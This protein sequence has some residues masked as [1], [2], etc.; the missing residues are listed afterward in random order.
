MTESTLEGCK[1]L[2]VED[3]FFQ[4]MDAKSWLEKAGAE[5]VG[6]TGFAEDVPALLH[7]TR[8]DAAVVDINL[9]AGA[10]Y[11]VAHTLRDRGVPFMFLTG[12]GSASVPDDLADVPRLAKP[13]NE[14]KVLAAVRDL[15]AA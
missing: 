10:S 1:I 12:Y 4:A 7:A 13:A 3:E 5:V 14:R 9:G 8:V 15:I 2:L 11:F 6:P